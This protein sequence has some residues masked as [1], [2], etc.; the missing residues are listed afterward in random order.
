M[1]EYIDREK[2]IPDRCYN[3]PEGY[4][5]VSVDQ[6][7]HEDIADVIEREKIDSA[8]LIMERE[9]NSEFWNRTFRDGIGYA[10]EILKKN[11]GGQ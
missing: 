3:E 1:A 2:L 7:F 9:Q 10:L 8:I 11:I 6:I 5:A 4:D